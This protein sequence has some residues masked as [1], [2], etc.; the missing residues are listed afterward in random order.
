MVI[1]AFK[2]LCCDMIF[3]FFYKNILFGEWSEFIILFEWRIILLK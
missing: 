1:N 3:I 2:M